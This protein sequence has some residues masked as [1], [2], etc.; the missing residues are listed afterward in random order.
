MLGPRRGQRA[1]SPA[2]W[3]RRQL[4]GAFAERGR[5]REAAE[6][7][8]PAGVAL[9]AG[10]DIFIKAG[11]GVR[12]MPGAELRAGAGVGDLREGVVDALALQ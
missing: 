4:R 12:A 1:A 11:R 9:Q 3:F 10:G 5:R 7:L 6:A 8:R 2:A